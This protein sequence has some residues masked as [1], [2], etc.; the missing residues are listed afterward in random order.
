ME[1]NSNIGLIIKE[2]RE[3]L[4]V[5]ERK[6]A[7]LAGLSYATL[8]KVERGV[9]LPSAKTLKKICRYLD[10]YYNDL[11]YLMG[12]GSYHCYLNPSMMN[13][14]ASLTGQDVDSA[15]LNATG[16]IKNNNNILKSL[17]KRKDTESF[18]QDEMNLLLDTIKDLEYENKINNEI[19]KVL[20]KTIF[21]ERFE[22]ERERFEKVYGC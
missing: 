13:Y 7:S 9:R 10:V 21:R 8:S 12:I 20:E 22:Y 14:Y 17:N 18:N 1:E 3:R 6:L 19:I 11:M 2:S 4:G 16:T 15:W 5:S